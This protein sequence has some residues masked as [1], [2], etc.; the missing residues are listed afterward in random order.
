M[1]RPSGHPTR[2][3]RF[4][5]PPCFAFAFGLGVASATPVFS[6]SSSIFI[7]ASALVRS[8]PTSSPTLRASVWRYE[9]WAPVIGSSPVAQSAGSL[10]L[11]S[12]VSFGWLIA[13]LPTRDL[14]NVP[15]S[16]RQV[17]WTQV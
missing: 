4:N 8:S 7:D 3:H 15:A 10:I 17:D 9:S 6:R 13:M 16:S 12:S 2:P 5:W 1:E 11:P 14:M